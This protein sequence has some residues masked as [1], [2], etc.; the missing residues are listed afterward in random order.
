[1]RVLIADDHELIRRTIRSFM[2][3]EASW[4]ICAEASNG[5]EALEI[6][7]ELRPDLVLLDLSMPVANGFETARLIRQEFPDVKILILSLGDQDNLLASA[8]QAGANG[9]VDKSRISSDL[10]PL[11]KK[12]QAGNHAGTPG[13]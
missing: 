13:D 6:A 4:E 1:M 5:Q 11:V 3:A 9:C 10:I 12:L 7:R 8:L 2:L